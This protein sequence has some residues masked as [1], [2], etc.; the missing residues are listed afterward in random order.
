VV[1]AKAVAVKRV[2]ERRTIKPRAGIV[3]LRSVC[4][5]HHHTAKRGSRCNGKM[6]QIAESG[7]GDW[8][9]FLIDAMLHIVRLGDHMCIDKFL[10]WYKVGFGRW[11]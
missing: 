11:L 8:Y 10:R 4:C 9:R 6:E 5:P 2:R 1:W 3:G 7:R